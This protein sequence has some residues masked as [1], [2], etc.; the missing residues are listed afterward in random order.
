MGQDR[1]VGKPRF[2]CQNCMETFHDYSEFEED[3]Q[4][5]F[6]RLDVGDAMPAGTC[7]HCGSLVSLN[8]PDYTSIVTRILET[9]AVLPLLKGLH[10]ELDEMIAHALKER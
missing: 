3:I 5:L 4:D 6:K 10:S 1:G 9:P 8:E 7:P 2:K